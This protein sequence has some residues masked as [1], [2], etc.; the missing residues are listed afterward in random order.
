MADGSRIPSSIDEFAPFSSN[1][2]AYLA[3]GTPSNATRLGVT[4]AELVTWQSFATQFA[5]LYPKYADKKNSRTTAIKDQ[6]LLIIRNCVL[7]NQTNHILDRIASSPN[8]TIADMETFNIKAGVLRKTTKTK[9]QTPIS[10]VISATVIPIGGGSLEIKCRNMNSNRASIVDGANCVQYA[11]VIGEKPPTG[12]EELGLRN[13]ISSKAYFTLN[14][15]TDACSKI[16]YIYFRWY[17]IKYP[18]LA[19][20]WSNMMAMMVL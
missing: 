20:P 13:Q 15:G 10:D 16:I 19:G 2:S 9:M 6:L 8:V 1:T 18:E 4:A 17:N 14:L 11:Y 3:A 5:A 12:A 7:F